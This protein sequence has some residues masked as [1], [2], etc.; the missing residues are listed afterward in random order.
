MSSPAIDLLLASRSPRRAEFLRML[1]VAFEPVDVEIDESPLPAEAPATYVR[2]LAC[3][4]ARAA[5]AGCPARGLPVLAADTTVVLDGAILGKPTDMADACAMHM[6]I[7]V[8][9]R[10]T[11][12]RAGG[13]AA[14][15]RRR[16]R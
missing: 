5:F 8:S 12:S 9:E 7:S 11:S 13:P 14:T 10:P 2:R 6:Y 16:A 3:G 4:K 15:A 1:G